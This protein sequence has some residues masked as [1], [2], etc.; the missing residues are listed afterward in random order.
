MDILQIEYNMSNNHKG[1][2]N[3][4]IHTLDGLCFTIELVH[5][6]NIVQGDT[7]LLDGKLKTVCRNNIRK[8]GFCG[9]TIH[10]ESFRLGLELV[11]RVRFVRNDGSPCCGSGAVRSTVV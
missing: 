5:K 6:D 7:I 9:T 10:G 3:K 1:V 2:S 8:G 11:K 4:A